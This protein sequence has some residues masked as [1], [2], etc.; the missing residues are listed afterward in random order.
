MLRILFLIA[1]AWLVRFLWS[2]LLG[3]ASRMQESKKRPFASSGRSPSPEPKVITGEM[4]KDPQCGTYV[5]T[6]LSLKSR[7]R[8]E[9]LHFCSRQCQEKFLEARADKSA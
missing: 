9:V 8:N 2:A 5:S 7:Y 6:E 3:G 4:K 1:V